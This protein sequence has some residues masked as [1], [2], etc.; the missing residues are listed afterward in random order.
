MF[1]SQTLK[2]GCLTHTSH[3]RTHEIS[4][5]SA[6]CCASLSDVV[7]VMEK[8]MWWGKE[9]GQGKETYLVFFL[10]LVHG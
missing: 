4:R 1:S 10:I 5:K 3:G 9:A 2:L 6:K 8:S 7:G